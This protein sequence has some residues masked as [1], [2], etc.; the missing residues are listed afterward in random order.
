MAP[1]PFPFY[2]DPSQCSFPLSLFPKPLAS[3]LVVRALKRFS[4]R[5]RAVSS[6][7]YFR[8][9]VGEYGH[10]DK[11]LGL[12]ATQIHGLA[13]E[14]RALSLAD[15]DKLLASPWHEARLLG[16]L[17][18]ANA[19]K[20]A[21]AAEREKIYRLYLRR[22]KRINNWDIVDLSAPHIVGAH[23]FA[24][25]RAPLRRLARSRNV[26]E[27]RIAIVATHYFIREGDFG[28][29][30]HLVRLLMRD[31]HDL[32]HKA[33]GWMLREVGKRDEATLTR[34]LDRYAGAL[35]RTALRYSLE[36]LTSAQRKRYMT[37]PR[38]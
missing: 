18:L 32:I 11:F 25:S 30:L 26:W 22:T 20:R 9:G 15:V 6:A 13:R 5:E 34:F 24:R 36:R 19:S 4:N 7:R 31:E 2:P 8:T 33:M 29:T 28:E 1:I 23:L 12:N 14:Y 35:P 3:A 38:R 21:Q 27:R 37:A 16:A 17:I 10:G